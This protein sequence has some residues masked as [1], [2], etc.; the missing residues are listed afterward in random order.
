M[1][2]ILDRFLGCENWRMVFKDNAA[3]N[4]IT[5]TSDCSPVKMEVVKKAR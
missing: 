3:T 1:E 4:M 2:E 5:W